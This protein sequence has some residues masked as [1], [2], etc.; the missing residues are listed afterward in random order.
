MGSVYFLGGFVQFFVGWLGSR[1]SSPAV[2]GGGG[3]RE[4]E[5][6]KGES[7]LMVVWRWTG[8]MVVLSWMTVSLWEV[9]MGGEGVRG[10]E[11]GWEW[12]G[13]GGE[14]F[15]GIGL[16]LVATMGELPL[17]SFPPLR[18]DRSQF[19]EGRR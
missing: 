19:R 6:D 13:G 12:V 17:L 14:R 4:E 11:G 16:R 10:V 2:G 15:V 18:F 9:H 7:R 5:E 8:A 1:I 3:G